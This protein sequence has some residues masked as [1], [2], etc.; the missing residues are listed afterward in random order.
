MILITLILILR[1]IKLSNQECQ[2]GKTNAIPRFKRVF[3]GHA[4][5]QGKFPWQMY[6]QVKII[7]VEHLG[8]DDKFYGG[9]LISKKHIV[10]CARCME[11]FFNL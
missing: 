10:T 2:C 1:M 5:P 4:A 7:N 11:D 8:N 9:A 6:L 3:G